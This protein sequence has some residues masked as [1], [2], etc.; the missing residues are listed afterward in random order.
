MG[1]SEVR[2]LIASPGNLRFPDGHQPSCFVALAPL[3]LRRKE[4]KTRKAERLMALTKRYSQLSVE[5]A[6]T[7]VAIIGP[8][9][10]PPKRPEFRKPCHRM[11]SGASPW[12][13]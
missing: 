13:G 9:A 10:F 4:A 7:E 2:G 3:P 11:G 8:R 5:K 6:S 12:K 1:P